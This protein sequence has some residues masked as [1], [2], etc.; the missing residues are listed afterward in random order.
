MSS[1]PSLPPIPV[2]AVPQRKARGFGRGRIPDTYDH[3]DKLLVDLYGMQNLDMK[4]I[5]QPILDKVQKHTTLSLEG[6]C[7]PVYHQLGKGSCVANA[8]A[9]ALRFAW[10]N[11]TPQVSVPYDEFEP[12]R[13]WIY[14]Y[15]RLV[16]NDR[17]HLE[18]RDTGCEIRNTLKVLKR[19]G[20]CRE[21]D[22][23]YL[24]KTESDN[25]QRYKHRLPNT[26]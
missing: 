17:I 26:S 9:A 14:Y 24:S 6:S 18:F 25:G 7:P 19:K 10:K 12:S 13:L 15:A 2:P 1:S 20:V 3:N 23:K 21:Q 11:S 4:E 8:T 16:E 5:Y 22:W